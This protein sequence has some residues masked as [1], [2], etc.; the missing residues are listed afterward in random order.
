MNPFAPHSAGILAPALDWTDPNIIAP[1]GLE[2]LAQHVTAPGKSLAL[3][4]PRRLESFKVEMDMKQS[5]RVNGIGA[6]PKKTNAPAPLPEPD[7]SIPAIKTSDSRK[8]SG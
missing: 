4:Q 1:T 7:Q 3:N 6:M 2:P 5:N 8:T